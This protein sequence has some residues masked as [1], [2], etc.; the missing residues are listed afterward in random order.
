LS[1][2]TPYFCSD[3]LF[4]IHKSKKLVFMEKK[5][6]GKIKLNQ[7]AKNEIER[8]TMKVLK[9]GCGCC[10]RPSALGEEGDAMYD[11][12]CYGCDDK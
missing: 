12:N 7:L 11:G 8:S 9:G 10:C 3:N 2:I 4:N 1:K 6:L 5:V